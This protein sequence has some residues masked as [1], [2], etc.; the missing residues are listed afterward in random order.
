MYRKYCMVVVFVW[1][2]HMSS[3]KKKSDMTSN[4]SA[5]MV[6]CENTAIFN[7]KIFKLD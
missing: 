4:K 2:K 6:Y 3:L 5:L 1:L 7:L